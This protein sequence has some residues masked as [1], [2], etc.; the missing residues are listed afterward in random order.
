[1]SADSVA[2]AHLL[3]SID[4]A[5]AGGRGGRGA[6]GETQGMHSEGRELQRL[7]LFLGP[8]L[9]IFLY[10]SHVFL[11]VHFSSLFDPRTAGR[12]ADMSG[13]VAAF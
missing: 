7:R 2:S 5:D 12:V 4:S 6:F 8:P 10:L 9:S 1:M 11:H 13:T 3:F